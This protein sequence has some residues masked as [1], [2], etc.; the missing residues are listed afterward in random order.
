M[1]LTPTPTPTDALLNSD[2]RTVHDAATV[3]LSALFAPRTYLSL[4]RV[5]SAPLTSLAS[6]LSINIIIS[7]TGGCMK[8]W[9]QFSSQAED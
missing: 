4:L 5:P 3:P 1:G 9:R 2:G 6:S 8:Y 7:R